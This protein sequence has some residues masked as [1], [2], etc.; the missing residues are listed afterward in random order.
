MAS[1]NE[2][3][4][5][6]GVVFETELEKW[7]RENMGGGG[8]T[9][10][11]TSSGSS[12]TSTKPATTYAQSALQD[13]KETYTGQ[14]GIKTR[15]E[16]AAMLGARE[17]NANTIMLGDGSVY[18]LKSD[19]TGLYGAG[20]PSAAYRTAY[21]SAPPL[22]GVAQQQQQPGTLPGA[23]AST[24]PY[25]GLAGIQGSGGALSP[26]QT[27]QFASLQGSVQP[28]A[29][30]PTAG[31]QYTFTGDDLNSLTVNRQGS[32]GGG[33]VVL[34]SPAVAPRNVGY[35]PGASANLQTFGS[36]GPSTTAASKQFASVPVSVPRGYMAGSSG[37]SIDGAGGPAFRAFDLPIN[38]T[39]PSATGPGGVGVITQQGP[40]TA[41]IRNADGGTTGWLTSGMAYNDPFAVYGR[42]GSS[43][44]A[45]RTVQSAQLMDARNELMALGYGPQAIIA[46]LTATNDSG[47]TGVDPSGGGYRSYG[48]STSVA[49]PTGAAPPVG[50]AAPGYGALGGAI[51]NMGNV[52]ANAASNPGSGMPGVSALAAALAAAKD[53]EENGGISSDRIPGYAK[54]G[55]VATGPLGGKPDQVTNGPVVG[56]R[57]DALQQGVIDPEFI[58]GEGVDRRGR[59]KPEMI[60]IKPVPGYAEGGEVSTED[61][62]RGGIMGGI[63]GAPLLAGSERDL[64]IA[65]MQGMQIG[66]RD[67]WASYPTNFNPAMVLDPSQIDDRRGLSP[68]WLGMEDVALRS[69]GTMRGELM[70]S[71]MP[72]YA[73]GG[74]VST[75]PTTAAV[76]ALP[77]LP[78]LPTATTTPVID[79]GPEQNSA[80]M[81]AKIQQQ[82]QGQQ[83]LRARAGLGG[84]T[85]IRTNAKLEGLAPGYYTLPAD[86][87]QQ[88]GD[89]QTTLAGLGPIPTDPTAL[90]TY[91]SQLQQMLTPMQDAL[92]IQNQLQGLGELGDPAQLQSLVSQVQQKLSPLK[93]AQTIQQKITGFG[94]V[95][96]PG[97]IQEQINQLKQNAG[98][99]VRINDLQQ[100]LTELGE[101]DDSVYAMQSGLAAL[102]ETYQQYAN[103]D[104]YLNP[105]E[106]NAGVQI[107]AQI[108]DTVNKIQQIEARNNQIWDARMGLQNLMA[109]SGY[110]AEQ[111]GPALAAYQ[112][113]LDAQQQAYKNA[114]DVAALRQELLQYAP[115]GTNIDALVGQYAA[116]LQGYEQQISNAAKGAQLRTQLGNYVPEGTDINAR[117]GEI[118]SASDQ[119]KGMYDAYGKAQDIY[120][121][122]SSYRNSTNIEGVE[123]GEA[124]APVITQAVVSTPALKA[125]SQADPQS[126]NALA[127]MDYALSS[128][129]WTPAT[130]QL[131]VNLT[132][133]LNGSGAKDSVQAML[134]GLVSKMA[135]SGSVPPAIASAAATGN[136]AQL[137]AAAKFGAAA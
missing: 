7:W 16:L 32:G 74:T 9:K 40:T 47:T 118:T 49:P 113:Q 59:F 117:I 73:E 54:G 66:P 82:Q 103:A 22:G 71:R 31:R 91:Q 13:K 107:Q 136:P 65:Q 29:G 102:K 10:P 99:L 96:D 55:R 109:A 90:T 86:Y 4:E 89:L 3:N 116:E 5:I 36:G 28:G 85:A 101:I 121:Q 127:R 33:P 63:A 119:A 53:E 27:P 126:A 60:D 128:G 110:T 77:P 124:P 6:S 44:A 34:G 24:S 95:G 104:P 105:F 72:Q 37:Y 98:P 81:T 133:S 45:T 134:Q 84:A 64:Q 75:A 112:T 79:T 39:A 132:N 100:K 97:A 30:M 38:S 50:A 46:A 106:F 67:S 108:A 122:I 131:L 1:W 35:G 114:L 115:E 26:T 135:S 51:A 125:I 120:K 94:Q 12:S 21:V 129:Q 123:Q 87:S 2:Y 69:L 41:S 52:V 23:P 48:G 78:T 80:L 43:D 20:Y 57:L 11:T 58:A 42:Q 19:G 8:S 14:P 62:E 25:A 130:S 93:T 56:V 18:N 76:T 17:L 61:D 92:G 15:E 68:M 137:A 70:A 111:L 83:M 88:I